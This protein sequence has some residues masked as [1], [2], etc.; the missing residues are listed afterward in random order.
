LGFDRETA[1]CAEFLHGQ[2]FDRCCFGLVCSGMGSSGTPAIKNH[3]CV[4]S[5]NT[6][7]MK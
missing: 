7:A 6:I 4:V 1:R 5:A 2:E 3:V